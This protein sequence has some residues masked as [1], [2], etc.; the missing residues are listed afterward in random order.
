MTKDLVRQYYASFGEQ[1]WQ[2]LTRPEGVIE[3]AVTTVALQRYLPPRGRVLDLGGATGRYTIW[4]A[5]HG[6][7]VVLA[8]LSPELLAIARTKIAEAGVGVQVEDVV[9]CD[10]CDLARFETAAFDAVLCLGPFYH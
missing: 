7:R 2:R 3:F 9:E 4:L 8:D 1:E 6:Y 5:Q 10:A